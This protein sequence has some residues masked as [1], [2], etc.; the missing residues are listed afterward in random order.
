MLLV[1]CGESYKREAPR[2]G[3]EYFPLY[4]DRQLRYRVIEYGKSSE[5]SMKLRFLGGDQYKVFAASFEGKAPGGIEFR[6]HGQQLEAITQYSYTS[7]ESPEK[8]SE[9]SQ[10]WI[11]ES[12]EPGGFWSDTDTGT[13]TVF[14][15][16]EDVTVPAGTF[17]DCYK[18]VTEALPE[19]PDSINARFD[20]GEMDGEML[21]QQLDNAKLVIIRWFARG[22]GLVK[23]KVGTSRFERELLAVEN[24][25]WFSPS[26]T[27]Q[28]NE[29]N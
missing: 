17:T 3:T 1:G 15:G 29:G 11:D 2:G 14:A 23:E 8:K 7:L 19:L 27:A 6:S 28:P 4:E 24:K 13:Q 26:A 25:G 20:R 12:L 16:Y 21:A 18:T 22:V 9:F 10:M 5:Y